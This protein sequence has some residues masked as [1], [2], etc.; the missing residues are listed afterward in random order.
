MLPSQPTILEVF[1][2]FVEIESGPLGQRTLGSDGLNCYLGPSCVTV[3]SRR[4]SHST[5]RVLL[6]EN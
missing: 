5:C 1:T 2:R 3:A 6:L 4:R